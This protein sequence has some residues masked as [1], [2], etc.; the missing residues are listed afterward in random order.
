MAPGGFSPGINRFRA[1]Y[2]QDK[3]FEVRGCDSGRRYRIRHGTQ[4]NIDQLD[5]R[6]R[7]VCGWCFLPEGAL[8][9][10]DVML[11]Q[12]IALETDEKAA[13]NVANRISDRMENGLFPRSMFD[14]AMT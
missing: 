7:R 8:V 1:S 12:K 2:K 14:L 9:A 5:K 11:A 13:L 3:F 10:G 6:G 4:M